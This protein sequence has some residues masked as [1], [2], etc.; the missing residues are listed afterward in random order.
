MK[1][2]YCGPYVLSKLCNKTIEEIEQDII[3]GRMNFNR[4]SITSMGIDEILLYLANC[5]RNFRKLAI[6]QFFD[7]P[8]KAKDFV[9]KIPIEYKALPVIFNSHNHIMLTQYGFID[10]NHSTGLTRP[11][12][13]P[14]QNVRVLSAWVIL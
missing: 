8:P 7:S 10:D 9:E 2:I 1:K 5:G 11:I 13:H 4:K 14:K 12:E 6:C 3:S